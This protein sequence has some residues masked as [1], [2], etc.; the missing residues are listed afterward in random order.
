MVVVRDGAGGTA[1]EFD[2]SVITKV[3]LVRLPQVQY[4]G[5]RADAH[6]ASLMGGKAECQLTTRGVSHHHKVLGI[7]PM[8]LRI[9]DQKLI[10]RTDV[11]K[12]SRPGA[13]VVAN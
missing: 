10:G 3:E 9:L 1:Q 2:D 13:T 8:F 12:R 4:A 11:S 7:E 6:H 5:Q